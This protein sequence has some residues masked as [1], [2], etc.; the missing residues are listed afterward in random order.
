MACPKK[1]CSRTRR[2]RR[3]SQNWKI[4]VVT[5]HTCKNCNSPSLP[6]QICAAC[7]FYKGR[8]VII[9]LAEKLIA[10]KQRQKDRGNQ[11]A[12]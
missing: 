11:A 6:H 12:A 10:R 3:R 8:K 9:P 7:G 4:H 5:S 2:D 1:K